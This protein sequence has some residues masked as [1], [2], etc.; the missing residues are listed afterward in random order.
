MTAT[1][2][3]D[4]LLMERSSRPECCSL[5]RQ[6]SVKGLLDMATSVMGV[7]GTPTTVVD[8]DVAIDIVTTS[9]WVVLEFRN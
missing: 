9:G 7:R 5:Y 4:F 6:L 1:K 8:V 3:G 2:K